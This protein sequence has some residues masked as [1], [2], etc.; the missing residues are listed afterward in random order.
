MC[1][2]P[3]ISKNDIIETLRVSTFLLLL[4][5]LPIRVTWENGQS[6]VLIKVP[7]RLNIVPA[8]KL[9]NNA[10]LLWIA[11]LRLSTKQIIIETLMLLAFAFSKMLYWR[12]TLSRK[13]FIFSPVNDTTCYM[14]ENLIV[15][16]PDSTILLYANHRSL[17]DDFIIQDYSPFL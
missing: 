17:L 16:Y 1:I 11:L 9:I 4:E 12:E 6:S 2:Q 14:L 13:W 8:G 15:Q 3:I 5:M 7:D 10:K